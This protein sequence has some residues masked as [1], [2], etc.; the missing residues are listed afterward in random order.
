MISETSPSS[1]PTSHFKLLLWLK[2][3][4]IY[5]SY[6]RDKAKIFGTVLMAVVF[7]PMSLSFAWFVYTYGSAHGYLSYF[8]ERDVLAAAF[9][10]WLVTPLVGF[11]LNDSYDPTR[12]F[13][14]PVK[15]QTIFAANVV[16]GLLEGSSLIILPVLIALVAATAKTIPGIVAEI[17]LLILFMLLTIGLSQAVTLTLIG[18]LRSRRFRDMMIVFF[19]LL[20][21]LRFAITPRNMVSVNLEGM[22]TGRSW[23]IANYLPPGWTASAMFSAATGDWRRT[24]FYLLSLLVGA[25]VTAGAA[26]LVLKQLFF[27]DRG[28]ALPAARSAVAADKKQASVVKEGRDIKGIWRPLMAI[29]HKEWTYFVRDPQYKAMA[30]RIVYMLGAIGYGATRSGSSNNPGAGSL[31]EG[32]I[33]NLFLLFAPMAV[34]GVVLFAS[35]P[36]TFNVF[37]GEG[38]AITVFFSF[39]VQR[40][41]LLI[42]KNIAHAAVVMGFSLVAV[43]V[44]LAVDHKYTAFPVAFVWLVIGTLVIMAAGNLVSIQFPAKMVARGGRFST[45]GL[46]AAGGSTGAANGCGR[47]FIYLLCSLAAFV[48]E[49]PAAACVV[50]PGLYPSLNIWYAISIPCGL[51]YAAGI[52]FLSLLVAD[53]WLPLRETDIIAKLAPTD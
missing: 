21:L 37:G 3:R 20:A 4:L 41:F 43:A 25:V 44:I 36:L 24:A 35:S 46:M 16:G 19:P 29:A 8:I 7:V 52:Y 10:F 26:G 12:L 1:V 38:A 42:G 30:G 33:H 34:V 13:V 18:F 53:S 45:G 6:R 48:V 17:I 9:F 15:Y 50:V 5:M 22:I 31:V 28:T 32:P 39:P 47:M 40:R 51:I 27:G 11:S 23:I 14:Y 49:L 2:F